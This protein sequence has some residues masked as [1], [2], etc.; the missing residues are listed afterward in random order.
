MDELEKRWPDPEPYSASAGEHRYFEMIDEERASM[1]TA[2]QAAITA[3]DDWTHTYAP[4]FCNPQ[5]VEAAQ[6]RIGQVGTIAYIAD[7][8]TQCRKALNQDIQNDQDSNEGR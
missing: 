8:V 2:L 5:R 4:E 7:V 6:E 3:L 1:R